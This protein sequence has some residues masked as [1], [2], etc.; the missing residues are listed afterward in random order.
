MARKAGADRP[1]TTDE[2]RYLVEHAGIDTV[3]SIC[4]ELRRSRRSVEAKA[5]RLRVSLRHFERLTVICPK[6]GEARAK[7]GNWQQRTGVCDVCRKRAAY[8]DALRRQAEAYEALDHVQRAVYDA[9]DAR[10]G[11]SKVLPR[12]SDPDTSGMDRAHAQRA[13]EL[14]AI[15]VERWELARLKLLTDAAKQRTKRMREKTG[16]NPRRFRGEDKTV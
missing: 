10:T 8:E 1:W 2:E 16:T 11:R 4:R 9:T 5:S 12:P 6:C 15:E 13:R 14:H 7:S 3:R